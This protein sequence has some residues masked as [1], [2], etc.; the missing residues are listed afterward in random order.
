M[1]VLVRYKYTCKSLRIPI[2]MYMIGKRYVGPFTIFKNWSTDVS[3]ITVQFIEKTSKKY[4][5]GP[6]F[7]LS[8]LEH[9]P[10]EV[11]R[12]NNVSATTFSYLIPI[13]K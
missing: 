13:V 11:R 1:C 3:R 8:G 4:P 5:P 10:L 9:D 2:N 12:V 6:E 7:S